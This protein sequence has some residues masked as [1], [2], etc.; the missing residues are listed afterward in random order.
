MQADSTRNDTHQDD[1]RRPSTEDAACLTEG[2]VLDLAADVAR[3]LI[4][5]DDDARPLPEPQALEAELDLAPPAESRSLEEVAEQLGR[6]LEF[7]PSTSGKRFFNQLFAGRDDA[8]LLG[9][10]VAAVANNSPYTYKAAGAQVLAERAIIAHMGR[11]VGWQTCAGLFTPGGSLSNFAAMVVAR[12][13]RLEGT[14][15]RG[16]D[17]RPIAFYTSAEAHYSIRKNAG[18]LGVGRDSV[19]AV[20]TD[21]QGRMSARALEAAIAKD[22]DAGV[23]PVMV[24]ATSGT[25]VQGAFDPLDQIA[26]VTG[27]RNIWLHVDGAFG[28]TL[29]LSRRR[30]H[31]LR[32]SDLADSF[33]WDAHKMMG[34]PLTSSVALFRDPEMPRKHF[35]ESASYLFQRDEADYNPGRSSLQCGRRNDALKLWTAWQRHGDLG[36][37]RRI[38]RQFELAAHARAVIEAETGWTLVKEPQSINLCFTIDGVDAREVCD[39]LDREGLAKVSHGTVDGVPTVRLVTA[40]PALSEEDLDAFFAEVRRA[41]ARLRK[42]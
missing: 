26:A 9:E 2:D 13:E 37:E 7:T 40:N 17:G 27:P 11:K 22:L 35:D 25:T 12:N 19:R 39:L 33:T 18:M 10:I 3:R 28:G 42:S 32:G 23:T 21:D 36:Y 38:E 20:D 5:R 6:L 29:L 8:A 1:W 41:A 16:L 24:I 14:R 4:A 15:E 34:V 31:L 30:R